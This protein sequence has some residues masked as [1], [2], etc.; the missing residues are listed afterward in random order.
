MPRPLMPLLYAAGGRGMKSG[1]LKAENG[2]LGGCG[3]RVRIATPACGLVRNDIFGECGGQSAAAHMG[4]ALQG[5]TG[6][7]SK[8]GGV[9]PRP[10]AE[11]G[12]AVKKECGLPRCFAL[13]N[14]RV[15]GRTEASALFV[16]RV[17][18]GPGRR[19]ALCRR[20][21][22]ERCG[23][24]GYRRRWYFAGKCSRCRRKS[25]RGIG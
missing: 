18:R 23:R 3:E 22:R 11:V 9:E 17:R 16:M 1:K 21:R 7:R 20:R 15:F 19:G 8:S 4:A 6:G 14:D 24:K 10:Y 13:R 25:G 5:V 12:G 2:K